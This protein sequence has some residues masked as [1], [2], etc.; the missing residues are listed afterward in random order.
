M[1]QLDTIEYDCFAVGRPNRTVEVDAPDGSKTIQEGTLTYK[2]VTADAL[3]MIRAEDGWVATYVHPKS[4]E[5]GF[6]PGVEL[7]YDLVGV[8]E[9]PEP[10]TNEEAHDWLSANPERWRQFR[11]ERLESDL[12][13]ADLLDGGVQ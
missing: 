6:A 9:L 3:P 8:L 13:A 10:M 1:T 2:L 5:L 11:D 12:T 4:D 7:R